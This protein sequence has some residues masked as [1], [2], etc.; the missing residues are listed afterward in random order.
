MRAIDLR[1]IKTENSANVLGGPALPTA[2]RMGDYKNFTQ[3][4]C[5]QVCLCRR[6]N[7]GFEKHSRRVTLVEEKLDIGLKLEIW[8]STNQH[9]LDSGTT[10]KIQILIASWKRTPL[11]SVC[12]LKLGFSTTM[13][14]VIQ[15]A[16]ESVGFQIIG[17]CVFALSS[18]MQSVI[19]SRNLSEY[20]LTFT[21]FLAEGKFSASSQSWLHLLLIARFLMHNYL[22]WIISKH[23]ARICIALCLAGSNKKHG[24]RRF[25]HHGSRRL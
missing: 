24:N 7:G 25:W 6:L 10:L 22:T 3:I 19:K 23:L 20:L 17:V 16:K 13:F 15:L 14:R 1:K 8:I 21:T 12:D 4:V 9:L 5:G 18:Q 11:A 2:K